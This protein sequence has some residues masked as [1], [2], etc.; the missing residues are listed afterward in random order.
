MKLSVIIILLLLAFYSVAQE[1][2]VQINWERAYGGTQDEQANSI[3]PTEDG[4]YIFTGFTESH[5]GDVQSGNFQSQDF[6]VVKVDKDGSIE[7]EQTYGGTGNDFAHQIVQSPDNNFLV[8]GYTTSNDGDIKSSN[9]GKVDFWLIK[10][11]EKGKLIWEKTYG[12]THDDH[13]N[14]IEIASDNGYILGGSTDSNDGDI[15]SGAKGYKDYWVVKIDSIGNIEWEQTYGRNF[16][17]NLRSICVIPEEG[18]F[19][20]GTK[21]RNVGVAKYDD[22]IW[23]L[24]IDLDG[25]IEWE[26]TYGGDGYDRAYQIKSLTNKEYVI[27]GHTLSN[28]GDVQSGNQGSYDIW[29]IKID[30]NGKLLW[31]KTFGGTK[32]ENLL[33]SMDIND[34]NEILVGGSSTSND[35][36]IETGNKGDWDYWIFNLNSKGEMI[37]EKTFG[38]SA[39]DYTY[40]IKSLTESEFMVGGITLSNDGDIKSGNHGGKDIWLVNV[41]VGSP[42]KVT[43]L[44]NFNETFD[45][46]SQSV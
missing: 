21:K 8:G 31:E 37:W 27:G 5:N 7:W 6:W 10:I 16:H 26:R 24:K 14:T 34:N 9:N 36:D 1:T 4:G 23:I 30:E 39:R 18:Y 25:N 13:L 28:D 45:T 15:Q 12:G 29:I 11:D 33:F 44:N 40:C 38:G 35:G 22:D 19:L 42:T 3:I 32:E 20:A 43:Q 46:V 2:Q 41:S 17:D